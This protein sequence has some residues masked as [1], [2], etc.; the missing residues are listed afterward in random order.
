MTEKYSLHLI[1]LVLFYSTIETNIL[2]SMQADFLTPEQGGLPVILSSYSKPTI[3]GTCSLEEET[4]Y[5]PG[6]KSY[7]G[8]KNTN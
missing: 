1:N 8:C 3:P 5:I 2:A 4:Y 7:A 6:Q